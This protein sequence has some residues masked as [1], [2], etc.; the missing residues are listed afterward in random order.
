MYNEKET[1]K[2]RRRGN[3]VG[4]E[5]VGRNNRYVDTIT[6]RYPIPLGL[7]VATASVASQLPRQGD[8]YSMGY[9]GAFTGS[10]VFRRRV[11]R[12]PGLRLVVLCHPR[13]RHRFTIASPRVPFLTATL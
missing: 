4:R 10:C 7:F 9:R 11:H 8:K 6:N 13:R 12:S 2:I 5:G 3:G 1:E